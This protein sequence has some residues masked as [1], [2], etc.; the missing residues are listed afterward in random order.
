VISD[1]AATEISCMYALQDGGGGGGEN[2]K[3]KK[4]TIR[5]PTP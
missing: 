1:P 5:M 4:F 3:E 2:E